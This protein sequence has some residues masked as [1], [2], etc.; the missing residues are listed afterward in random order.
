MSREEEMINLISNNMPQSLLRLNKPFQADSEMIDIDGETYFFNIDNFSEEDM[1]FDEDPYVL[2][3]NMAVGCI[4]DIFASGGKPLF[5][6]HSFCAKKEWTKDYIDQ[7]SKGISDVLR[8]TS[9][10]FIGGDFSISSDWN[11]TGSVIGKPFD[12][13]IM[14]SGAKDGDKLFITGKIGKGNIHAGLKLFP[15][16]DYLKAL[17]SNFNNR[18]SIRNDE[19]LFINQYCNC[20][21]DTSDGVF[22][23][24][25]NISDINNTGYEITYVPFLEEGTHMANKLCIPVELLFIGECGEY[26][27][28]F[29]VGED[30]YEEFKNHLEKTHYTMFEIGNITCPDKRLISTSERKINLF[31]F[32]KR[33]RDFDDIKLYLNEIKMYLSSQEV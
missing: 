4:S 30:K 15:D 13:P 26:E 14:R 25:N 16:N 12:K 8:Q 17:K 24:L 32:K 10:V 19:A 31:D 1:F 6:A 9:T 33:A 2:G 11:Y 29:A 18:F 23:A 22:N 27:L 7:L 21:I 20:C 5:Y 3:W 28:L